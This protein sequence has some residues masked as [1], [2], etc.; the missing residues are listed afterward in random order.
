MARPSLGVLAGGVIALAA[1]TLAVIGAPHDR[2]PATPAPAPA[3]PPASVS[4][5]GVTLASTAIDLPGDEAAYPD[6]PH[7]DLV[8]ARCAACHSAAMVLTQPRLSAEQWA[9]EVTKMREVYKA[10]VAEAE[11]AAIVAYLTALPGQPGEPPARR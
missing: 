5:G 8:N 1:L 3:A 2:P 6:G 10:P 7:A 4:A 11:T 9:A